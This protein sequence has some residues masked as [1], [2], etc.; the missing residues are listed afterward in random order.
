MEDETL[1]VAEVG[2]RSES[3][4]VFQIPL[5]EFINVQLL[6][7]SNG[8]FCPKDQVPIQ[9]TLSPL[10]RW[11]FANFSRHLII[12]FSKWLEREGLVIV[13]TNL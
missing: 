1:K 9:M 5:D 4:H 2:L 8:L 7:L 3:S 13:P 6:Y 12:L 11:H 10:G